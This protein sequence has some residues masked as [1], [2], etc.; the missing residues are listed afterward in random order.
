MNKKRKYLKIYGNK[1]ETDD[2]RGTGRIRSVYAKR[3][4]TPAEMEK[5]RAV[6]QELKL[7]NLEF[8]EYVK[9][10]NWFD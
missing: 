7:P 2:G 4:C 3:L 5:I 6:L 9:Q 1:E 8:D 10:L